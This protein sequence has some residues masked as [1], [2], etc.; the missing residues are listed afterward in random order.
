[1]SL[2]RCPLDACA[3]VSG[4]H[5]TKISQHLAL[6]CNCQV[7]L[8]GFLG[9]MCMGL[10]SMGLSDASS[11]SGGVLSKSSRSSGSSGCSGL[12]SFMV[13]LALRGVDI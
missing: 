4:L 7:F 13:F 10:L 12:Y 8:F 5:L 11:V 3:P 2:V 6:E 9:M 1:M